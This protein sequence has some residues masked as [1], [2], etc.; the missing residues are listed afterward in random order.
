MYKRFS[1][2]LVL[3]AA[4]AFAGE[5]APDW[6]RE[7]ATRQLPAYSADVR[8][9][10]LVDEMTTTARPDGS[11][12]THIRYA[13]RIISR[14]GAGRAVAAAPYFRKVSK[15]QN[16]QA[17]LIM[18]DG[19][20]RA[21]GKKDVLDVAEKE[22]FELY[23][24]VRARVIRAQNPPPGSTFAW[25]AEFEDRPLLPQLIWYFQ[26][27]QPVLSSRCVLTLPPGWHAAATTF[28][29]EPVAPAVDG[30][31]YTWELKNLGYIKHE[32]RSPATDS[33][34]PWLGITYF[35]PD[36]GNGVRDWREVGMF[37]GKLSAGQDTADE[38]LAGEVR[39]LT[40]SS[41]ASI[42]QLRALARYVQKIH[43]V[44]ISLDIAHGGGYRPHAAAEVFQKQYGDCKDKANLLH[45]MLQQI[46][47]R[48]YLVAVYAGDRNHVHPEWASPYPFNHMIVA[49]SVPDAISFPAVR[50][51][52]NLG[53][54]LFFD[55]TDSFIPLGLLPESEQSSYGLVIAG[56]N[57]ELLRLPAAGPDVNRSDV[58]VE[59]TLAPDGSLDA[60]ITM[61][62]RAE[63]ASEL[64]ALRS[65]H[66][67]DFN[68]IID[69]WLARNVKEVEDN[70]VDALDSFDSGEMDLNV[71]FKAARFGQLMQQ[72]LLIF[73]PAVIQPFWTFPLQTDTRVNPLVLDA[74][75]YHQEVKIKLPDNFKVDEL[76]D[77]ATINSPFGKYSATYKVDGGAVLFTEDLSVSAVTLPAEKYTEA[78]DFFSRVAGAERAPLVLVKN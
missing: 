41:S 35:G 40:A 46:G 16:L 70:G 68:R 67:A 69:A 3:I 72:R 33:L 22:Q 17:W 27:D 29:H 44:A 14:E 28:N 66:S 53:R 73:K 18:A 61:K 58:D 6:V 23:Q 43:Y 48:S 47:I 20:V 65:S 15:I 64:R 55:P 77:S 34:A 54:L 7:V 32:S 62:Q 36:S 10:T 13:I 24:D 59:G 63:E 74:E 8:T 50:T 57:S 37:Q 25:S 38:A 45:T 30:T 2:C 75:S 56:E 76:P 5:S 1:I 19:S 49:I 51:D 78:K 11:T 60:K 21:Y 4:S 39:S 42:G 31:T 52:P 71:K 12:L 26:Q 9:A